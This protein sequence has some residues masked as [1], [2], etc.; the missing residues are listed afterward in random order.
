M[1]LDLLTISKRLDSFLTSPSPHQ[2]LLEN[3]F[4]NCAFN[5][6]V[7]NFAISWLNSSRISLLYLDASFPYLLIIESKPV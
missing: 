1:S 4:V 3:V 6:G 2:G 7:L 5:S